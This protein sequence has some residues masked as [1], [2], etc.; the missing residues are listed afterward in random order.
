M[1]Y[2][3]EFLLLKA[4]FRTYVGAIW[5]VD[6]AFGF[7]K[8]FSFSLNTR[9]VSEVAIKNKAKADTVFSIYR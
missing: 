3:E 1:N 9:N 8:S 5:D 2:L 7:F 6:L 4:V